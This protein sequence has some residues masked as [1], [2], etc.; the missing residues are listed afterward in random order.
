V[1]VNGVPKELW[2]GIGGWGGGGR[3]R[4][5]WMYSSLLS[6][7]ILILLHFILDLIGYL[8]ITFVVHVC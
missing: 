5:G 2:E 3:E 1:F 8:V 7:F 4:K 6:H